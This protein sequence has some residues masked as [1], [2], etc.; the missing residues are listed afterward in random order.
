M[1][2]QK[3]YADVEK[4]YHEL[5]HL[6]SSETITMD[7]RVEHNRALSQVTPLYEQLGQYLIWQKELTDL[8][9]MRDGSDE[10]M[11]SIVEEER[12]RL[13]EN[14]AESEEQIKLMML[15]KDVADE[16]G[17]VLEIRA[18]TG[19]DEAG[20]FVMDLMR[21]YLRYIQLENWKSEVVECD[22]NALGGSS[23]VI[24]LIEGDG[25]Y[26]KL[27][28]EGGVHRVQRIPAT[29]SG[30]RIHTSTVTVAVLAKASEVDVELDMGDLRIDTYRAQ[31]AGGQ[32]VNKTD[33][34]VR[35]TH[36][37]SGIVAQCQDHKSQHRNR[38]QA[39]EVLRARLYDIK[40]QEGVAERASNRREQIGSGDR[41]ERIRTY[42][43]PQGRVTDHR[44]P[45]TLYKLEL[46]LVGEAL[47]ELIEPLLLE[48][49]RQ[50]LASW[51]EQTGKG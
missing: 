21:M 45:I 47:N 44:L 51:E 19:G 3:T 10:E 8:D 15:P 24:L 7:E 29:E 38:Q 6:L 34:A 1:D 49:R 30:G 39:M 42:N 27:R 31:G 26:G 14:L 4:R 46:I 25:V 50:L 22:E 28:L 11:L 2:W 32:H 13:E 17:A 5:V 18:G 36:I 40:R 43:F 16:G 12:I 20:L 35:I 9:L 41:S 37:P 23:R 48:E 33:S